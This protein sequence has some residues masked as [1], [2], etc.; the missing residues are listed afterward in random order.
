MDGEKKRKKNNKTQVRKYLYLI[1]GQPSNVF[2]FQLLCLF[3]ECLI[4]QIISF[5]L[6]PHEIQFS[7]LSGPAID[8]Q[9]MPILAKKKSS[10]QIKLILILSSM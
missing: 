3:H 10:F 1:L 7:S 9:K 4:W 6:P 8:L 5:I 2:F